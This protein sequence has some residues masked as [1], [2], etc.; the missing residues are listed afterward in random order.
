MSAPV[1]LW[2]GVSP[3]IVDARLLIPM[4][5]L[6]HASPA[7]LPGVRVYWFQRRDGTPPLPGA[8][9][10]TD[11]AVVLWNPNQYDE[12]PLGHMLT[13]E[14]D[15]MIAR[16]YERLPQGPVAEHYRRA[17]IAAGAYSD[18]AYYAVRAL[19]RVFHV[20]SGPRDA[21]EYEQLN[22]AHDVAQ[23]T[24]EHLRMWLWDDHGV[25]YFIACEVAAQLTGAFKTRR[26]R[27]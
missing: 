6:M 12:W 26:I 20:R 11:G 14:E 13:H 27:Y 8:S 7:T 16:R 9:T 1:V 19:D 23:P 4:Q 18:G 21:S 15:A 10:R 3:A 17:R 22:R 2:S 5:Y 25:P 24:Y